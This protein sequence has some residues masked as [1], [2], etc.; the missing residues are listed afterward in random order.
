M[1]D[2]LRN[3]GRRPLLGLGVGLFLGVAFASRLRA[4]PRLQLLMIRRKGCAYCAQW[5]SEIAPIYAD[6]PEG[7]AAPLLM[8][9]VNGPY[10]DGLALDRMPWLTPGFILLRD[11]IE[12]T[13][14]EGYPGEAHF[15]PMLRKML[16]A[17]RQAG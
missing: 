9:D 13:R 17:A 2:R 6:H 8:V 7:R 14:Y 12:V 5:D 15:F 4:A 10:P 3:P 1:K 11:G 16:A